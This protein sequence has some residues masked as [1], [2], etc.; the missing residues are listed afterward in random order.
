MLILEG[1]DTV[2]LEFDSANCRVIHPNKAPTF[3]GRASK[4]W[5]KLYV[6]VFNNAPIYIGITRQRISARLKMGWTARGESGYHGYAWRR[7]LTRATLWVWYADADQGK[8]SQRELETIEA[9]IVYLIREA[10]QWPEFQTEIHFHQSTE[11]HRLE[12][13]RV[14]AALADRT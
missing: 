8:V 13:R 10:G 4:A 2:E 6:A 5:P 14:L 12:A 9:E 7:H 1:P 11:A 3:T